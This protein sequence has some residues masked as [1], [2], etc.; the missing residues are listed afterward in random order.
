MRHAFLPLVLVLALLPATPLPAA[1]QSADEIVEKHL[2]ALGGREALN[3]LT[4]RK[5]TG[6]VVFSTP[7]GEFKGPIELYNKAPNKA[8]ALIKL[9]LSAAGM[10]EPMVIDQRFDGTSGRTAN[11]VQGDTDISGNQ[12]ENMRN[13]MFPSSLLNYKANGVKVDVQPKETVEGTEYL[14]LLMTPKSG[15]AVKMYLDP[16]TYLVARTSAK[17][18]SPELG[19]FEQ[20]GQ[21]SDYRVVDGIKMPFKSVNSS[22]QQTVTILIEKV[23]NNIAIDDA[24]FKGVAAVR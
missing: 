15:S 14:V 3:K 16:A 19:E 2:A 1:V 6:T 9:D 10:T 17:I 11:S 23:E 12:L 5:A 24:M 13:N 20:T 8:R 4:S 7:G 21:V 18:M 22:P